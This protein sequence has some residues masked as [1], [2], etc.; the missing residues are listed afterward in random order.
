M[1]AFSVGFLWLLSW[2]VTV[3]ETRK[4]CQGAFNSHS[5]HPKAVEI[6][7][8]HVCCDKGNLLNKFWSRKQQPTSVFLPGKSNAHKS[9]AVYSP[10]GCQESDTTA[11]AH[12]HTL[13]K[14]ATQK[15]SCCR[16]K[17]QKGRRDGSWRLRSRTLTHGVHTRCFL[18]FTSFHSRTILEYILFFFLT[19]LHIMQDLK[20]S[21]Q[22]SNPQPLHWKCSLNHW[23]PREVLE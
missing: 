4:H 5:T 13:N 15:H 9:L 8:K 10:W 11:R 6:P 20:F 22:G 19:T 14:V 1:L 2:E 3:M 18:G 7:L 17:A 16:N 21:D 23:T 12:M